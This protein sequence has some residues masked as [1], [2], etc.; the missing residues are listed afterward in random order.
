MLY[1]KNELIKV[2]NNEKIVIDDNI[3]SNSLLVVLLNLEIIESEMN[4][5][6]QD[7]KNVRQRIIANDTNMKAR[8]ENDR[9]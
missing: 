4:N 8:N 9:K 1:V 5:M 6:K 7:V 2:K 3:E